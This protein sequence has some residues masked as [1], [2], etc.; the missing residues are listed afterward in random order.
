MT[1]G[2]LHGKGE[3]VQEVSAREDYHRMCRQD[4]GAAAKEART[5]Q[6]GKFTCPG[7]RKTWIV[8]YG[9][10]SGMNEGHAHGWSRLGQGITG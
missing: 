1:T 3:L 2:L 6:E 5:L 9:Y 8:E 10:S 4:V 7:W